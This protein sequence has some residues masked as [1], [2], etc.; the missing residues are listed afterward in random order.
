MKAFALVTG[1]AA[2]MA[3]CA[4]SARTQDPAKTDPTH[5]KVVLE[6]DRTRV[7]HVTVAP[8]TKVEV[9]ELDDAVVVPLANYESNLKTADGKTTTVERVTG[10]PEWLPGGAREFE[11]GSKGVDALLIE[12]KRAP[13]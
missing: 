6:N 10:K 7:L 9:H 5:F 4:A 12:I 3:L 11:A 1:F 13:K 2:V 8:N